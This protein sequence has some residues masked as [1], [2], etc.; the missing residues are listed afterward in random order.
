MSVTAQNI[1]DTH[2]WLSQF[3]AASDALN[4]PHWINTFFAP[5]ATIRFA[6]NPALVGREEIIGSFNDTFKLLASMKHT[7]LAVDVLPEKIYQEALITYIVKND[8]EQVP[9][10]V[11]GMAV[12]GK[13]V[14]ESTVT[15]FDV[16]LDI[17][18]VFARIAA[19]VDLNKG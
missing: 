18:P 11:R 15:F 19:V 17:S 2:A 3:H 9:I 14:D 16:Y 10:S 5:N 12:F 8:P 1:V 6:N 13:K 4:A 7:V